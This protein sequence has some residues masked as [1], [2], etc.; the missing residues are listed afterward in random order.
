MEASSG[1]TSNGRTASDAGTVSSASTAAGARRASLPRTENTIVPGGE[2]SVDS[3]YALHPAETAAIGDLQCTD[4]VFDADGCTCRYTLLETADHQTSWGT[5]GYDRGFAYGLS[6]AAPTASLYLQLSGAGERVASERGELRFV[7]AGHANFVVL[8]A[9]ET[10]FETSDDVRGGTFEVLLS[11]GY[12]M[13]LADRH[14]EQLDGF[15]G[16]V[17]RNRFAALGADPL[18]ITGRMRGVVQRLQQAHAAG[19]A[20][21]LLL[22]SGITE[23]LGLLLAQ[24]PSASIANGVKLSRRDV[25]GLHAARDLLLA[26]IDAPPTLAQLARHAAMNEFKLKRGFRALFGTT[27]YACFLEHRLE[28]AR[29]Y[30]LDT[31]WPVARIARHVGYRDPAHLST[32]FR[33]RYGVRP[34]DLRRS[35]SLPGNAPGFG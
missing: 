5:Y 12:F 33:R 9:M 21:S 26:R 25:D 24:P 6:S 2:L 27:P 31:D 7:R 14:P 18:P 29:A 13:A 16:S 20:G 17:Q 4:Y 11:P 23:L 35:R 30:L 28:H 10:R 34:T 3:G 22:E 19:S 1:A 8:P 15:A 32:A